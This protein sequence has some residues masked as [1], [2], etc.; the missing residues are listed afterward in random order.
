MGS[1]IGGEGGVRKKKKKKLRKG[2]TL[3]PLKRKWNAECYRA[4]HKDG[5]EH[6][7]HVGALPRSEDGNGAYLRAG[8][9]HP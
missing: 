4:G 2:G 9:S 1:G 5:Q 6:Q 3:Q 7:L 8:P